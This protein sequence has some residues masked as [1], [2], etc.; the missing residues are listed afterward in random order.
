MNHKAQIED[1]NKRLARLENALGNL[2]SV[3]DIVPGKR[4]VFAY[5]AEVRKFVEERMWNMTLDKCAAEAKNRFGAKRAPSRT[6]IHRH[7]QR[8]QKGMQRILRPQ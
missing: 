8:L 2:F 4:A 5:D 1:L 6:A 7:R 3:A